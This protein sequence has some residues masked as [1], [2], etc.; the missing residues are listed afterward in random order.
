MLVDVDGKPIRIAGLLDEVINVY[1][2]PDR[3]GAYLTAASLL[4]AAATT[5]A[6]SGTASVKGDQVTI[7]LKPKIRP[8]LEEK[9]RED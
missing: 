2:L 3:P 5:V 6:T 8:T 7:T 9:A 1:S 4:T